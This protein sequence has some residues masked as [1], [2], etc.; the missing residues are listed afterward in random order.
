MARVA[1]YAGD[2][3]EVVSVGSEF[4][5]GQDVVIIRRYYP[6]DSFLDKGCTYGA[7][8]LWVLTIED[9]KEGFRWVDA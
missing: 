7:H 6:G 2:L 5:N 3:W 8:G 4:F 1:E 9:F